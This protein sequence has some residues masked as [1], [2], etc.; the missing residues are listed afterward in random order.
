MGI[1][2]DV[3]GRT[4]VPRARCTAADLDLPWNAL[5]R[6]L[7]TGYPG[8]RREYRQRKRDYVRAYRARMSDEQREG[9]LAAQRVGNMTPAQVE[10]TR[11]KDRERYHRKRAGA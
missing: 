2:H 11:Q 6:E 5:I 9:H 3:R 1:A 10:R 8:C 4:V 7:V